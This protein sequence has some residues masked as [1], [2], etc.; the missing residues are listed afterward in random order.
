MFTVKHLDLHTPPLCVVHVRAHEHLHPNHACTCVH[1]AKCT[2]PQ[3]HALMDTHRHAP[4]Q[5]PTWVCLCTPTL[6]HPHSHPHKHARV[7]AH[8]YPFAHPCTS[9][10][11]GWS[12]SPEFS[13]IPCHMSA[14]SHTQSDAR[15]LTRTLLRGCARTRIDT[16]TRTHTHPHTHTGSADPPA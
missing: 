13:H 7:R 11:T 10:H 15:V 4:S 8:I 6:V 16:H 1:V 2:D 14:L 3:T 5:A 9:A 12:R